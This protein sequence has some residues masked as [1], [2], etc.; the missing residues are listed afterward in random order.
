MSYLLHYLDAFV[1][2]LVAVTS[3]VG[4]LLWLERLVSGKLVT[5]VS[6][7]YAPSKKTYNAYLNNV[8]YLR[9][10]ALHQRD[11]AVIELLWRVHCR[12]FQQNPCNFI[13]FESYI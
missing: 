5:E 7:T 10:A 9:S 1:R 13:D 3:V 12:W 11:V 8:R 6:A 4:V 2:D